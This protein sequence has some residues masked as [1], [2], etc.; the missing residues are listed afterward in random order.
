MQQRWHRNKQA[1]NTNCIL[2]SY[3]WG[4]VSLSDSYKHGKECWGVKNDGKILE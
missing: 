3:G 2:D 4:Q 1:N